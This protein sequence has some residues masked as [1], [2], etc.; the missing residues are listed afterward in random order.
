MEDVIF[1]GT[2]ARP[3]L[4]RAE[5][6]LTIDNTDGALPIDYTE[7]TIT[8][9]M[10]R[11]G[12]SEYAINGTSCRLLDV[13]GLLSDSGLGREMH[14]IVGQ[15][16]LDTVLRATPRSAGASS[17]RP[18][19]SSS[20]AAANWALLSRAMGQPRPG[21]DLTGEIRRQLGLLGRQAEAARRGDPGRRP[22]RPPA[23]PR[24]RPR[25]ASRLS[26]SRRSPTRPRSSSDAPPSRTPSP[27]CT[28]LGD[29]EARAAQAAP[30]LGRPRTGSCA[31]RAW[32]DRLESTGSV[33]AER[34]RLLSQDEEHETTSGRDPEELRPE[35]RRPAR[36]RPPC[37]PRSPG[38]PRSSR[39]PWSCA[40]RWRPPTPRSRSD[41][42]A[43]RAQP[44]TAVRAPR[45][46]G[47]RRPP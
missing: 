32:S 13:Q 29:V 27:T 30:E 44:P 24:R 41:W 25:A 4:G 7:V 9:T 28:R 37:W 8:R 46:A 26:S 38:P 17:R 6:S 45:L 33:A 14:V 43:S 35:P 20:T 22:G 31:C 42:P 15:G 12:G 3:P 34:V 21:P 40:R 39:M 11:G 36:R 23:H 10:F 18:R 19:A 2:A 5:V 1:A 16:Q 47:G